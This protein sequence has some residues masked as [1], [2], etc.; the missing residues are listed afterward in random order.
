MQPLDIGAFNHGPEA[1]EIAMRRILL[2]VGLFLPLF[3]RTGV[4]AGS[5]DGTPVSVGCGFKFKVTDDNSG[6]TLT[7][8]SSDPIF[9]G[10]CHSDG[11]T[12]S[13]GGRGAPDRSFTLDC[14]LAGTI[15][16]LDAKKGIQLK[17]PGLTVMRCRVAHFTVGIVSRNDGNT[18]ADNVVEHC[19]R[20]GYQI[21]QPISLRREPT[22]ATINGNQA[23]NN[24]GFGFALRG[25]ALSL[26][27]GDVFIDD[28]AAGN[29]L[30]GFSVTSGNGN[31]LSACD[32]IR[33]GGPGFVI[34]NRDCCNL[35]S[36]DTSRAFSNAGPGIV[37]MGRDDGSNCPDSL[38]LP[39]GLAV[40]GSDATV[41][42]FDNGD[43]ATTCP[44]RTGPFL[45]ALGGPTGAQI[46][47]TAG[48]CS[49]RELARCG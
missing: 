21:T 15:A 25:N 42:A 34:V 13:N 27:A 8:D 40:V 22:G 14:A 23:L 31:T 30:G 7:L 47:F 18:V 6:G 28:L 16:G 11:I 38:C 9:S 17:G 24:G 48:K 33:N 37:Y 4:Q 12:I 44:S 36:M 19:T 39:A 26:A 3:L 10:P 35:D 49:D 5:V 29:A 46:C 41:F 43:T 45:G 32:A 2:L 20:D 1:N